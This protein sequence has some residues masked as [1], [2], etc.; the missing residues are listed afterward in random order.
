MYSLYIDNEFYASATKLETLY[1]YLYTCKDYKEFTITGLNDKDMEE[2]G[3]FMKG[4][5]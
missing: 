1:T 4:V 5:K 3:G 2:L